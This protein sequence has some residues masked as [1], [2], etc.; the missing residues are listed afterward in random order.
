VEA[1]DKQFTLRLYDGRRLMETP[2]T[3]LGEEE[4]RYGRN[5]RAQV[6]HVSAQR[7]PITGYTEKELKSMEGSDPA[8][9]VLFSNDENFVPLKLYVE[10]FGRIYA[11]RER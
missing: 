11:V 2:Y 5:G 10:V 6:I 4:L 7:K 1:G 8:M 9:H 3:V